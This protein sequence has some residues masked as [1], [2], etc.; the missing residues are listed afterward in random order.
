[1]VKGKMNDRGWANDVNVIENG[2]ENIRG[3]NPIDIAMH[4]NGPMQKKKG[5]TNKTPWH[6]PSRE[7]I[8]NK[9]PM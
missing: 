2:K 6:A 1:M 8:T 9:S 5:P 4:K 3:K 7:W